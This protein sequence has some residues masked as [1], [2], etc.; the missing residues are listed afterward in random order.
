MKH[1][2]GGDFSRPRWDGVPAGDVPGRPG[3][4]VRDLFGFWLP[5][6]QGHGWHCGAHLGRSKACPDTRWPNPPNPAKVLIHLNLWSMDMLGWLLFHKSW[7]CCVIFSNNEINHLTRFF[8]M[9]RNSAFLQSVH[10]LPPCFAFIKIMRHWYYCCDPEWLLQH[11]GLW[12]NMLNKVVALS[13]NPVH[14]SGGG[15]RKEIHS[16]V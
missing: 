2:G 6:I 1:Q 8:N 12:V 14:C 9:N 10:M 3:E 16:K 11:V 15:K 7:H 5:A 4:G 13:F